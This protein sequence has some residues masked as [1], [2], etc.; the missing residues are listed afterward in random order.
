MS[1]VSGLP[2]WH[3]TNVFICLLRLPNDAVSSSDYIVSKAALLIS[4]EFQRMW[5]WSW[6]NVRF[7]TGILLQGLGEMTQTGQVQSKTPPQCLST[8]GG[9]RPWHHVAFLFWDQQSGLHGHKETTTESS[10]SG[11]P[12]SMPGQVMWDLCWTKWHWGRFSLSTS[13]SPANSQSTDCSTIIIIYHPRL[14]P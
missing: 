8:T 3:F 10:H 7:Y 14:V 6:P 1:R 5:K 4:N 11:D 13:V 9:L 12:G 2:Q